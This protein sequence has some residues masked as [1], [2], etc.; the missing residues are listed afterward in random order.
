[1]ALK[2]DLVFDNGVK[3]NYHMIDDIQVDNKNKT[4]KLKV[5]SYTDE[6]YRIK[7]VENETNKNRYNDLLTLITTEN[8]KEE[9]DRDV[10]QVIIWSDEA[11]KLVPTFRE[12]LQLKVITSDI[13]LKEVYDFNLSNLYTLLKQESLFIGAEDC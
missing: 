7:E 2:K 10:P 9:S 5:V 11:N 13:E 1:M 4:V 6:T 8:E 3:I 12:D